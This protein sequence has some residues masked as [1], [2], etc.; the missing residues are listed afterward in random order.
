MSLIF[1][2]TTNKC[3]IDKKIEQKY[4]VNSYKHAENKIS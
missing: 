3:F 4:F 1:E 2:Q